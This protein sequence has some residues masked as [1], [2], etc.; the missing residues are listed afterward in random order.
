MNN[1]SFSVDSELE[2]EIP[3]EEPEVL[4]LKE[5]EKDTQL[6]SSLKF[7][8]LYHNKLFTVVPKEHNIHL[9]ILPEDQGFSKRH[10]F[11]WDNY[12]VI[13]QK[14]DDWKHVLVKIPKDVKHGGAMLKMV[15]GTYA[16][17]C[18]YNT[19][20]IEEIKTPPKFVE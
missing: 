6:T 16:V 8:D 12:S 10:V 9:G 17:P 15:G 18:V 13:P 1:L 4:T 14:F 7:A 2:K 19:W 5:L 11:L 3:L 20:E